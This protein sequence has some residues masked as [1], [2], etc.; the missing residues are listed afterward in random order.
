MR[1]DDQL[2][3]RMHRRIGTGLRVA[4]AEEPT[5]RCGGDLYSSRS[6]SGLAT[7][8]ILDRTRPVRTTIRD[9]ARRPAGPAGRLARTMVSCNRGE[10]P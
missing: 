3:N 2:R 8:S 9:V 4:A 7:Y 5:G 10:L 1:D 6:R